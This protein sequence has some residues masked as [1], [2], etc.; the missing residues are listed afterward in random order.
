VTATSIDTAG[1][2]PAETGNRA[3][4]RWAEQE[5]GRAFIGLTA[6]GGNSRRAYIVTFLRVVLYPHIFL[7]P[8]LGLAIWLAFPRHVA[9]A[10]MVAIMLAYVIA[11]GVAVIQGVV[12][13]HRRPWISVVSVRPKLDWRRL[14]IG[15]SVQAVLLLPLFPLNYLLLGQPLPPMP[16]L[17]VVLIALALTPLQAASEEI[18]FRGYLTQALGRVFHSRAKIIVAVG[19]LFAMAHWNAYGNL[20]M[21]YMFIVSVMLSFVSLRDEGLELTIG[22]HTAMNWIGVGEIGEIAA[23]HPLAQ[24]SWPHVPGLIVSGVL[25]YALTRL[26]V[27]RLYNNRRIAPS[28]GPALQT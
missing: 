15:A 8:V 22:A 14:A 7:I 11:G 20:T 23:G 6:L 27:R 17:S 18:L 5:W 12:R 28:E 26:A 19:I 3:G 24:I 4:S 25:F 10:A 1:N 13:S 21:P 2:P 9:P 16:A